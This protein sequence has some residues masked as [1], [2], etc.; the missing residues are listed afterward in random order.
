MYAI[1]YLFR[2]VIFSHKDL[3]FCFISLR[4]SMSVQRKIAVINKEN[5]NATNATHHWKGSNGCSPLNLH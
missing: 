1:H 2:P 3:D 5:L 4:F